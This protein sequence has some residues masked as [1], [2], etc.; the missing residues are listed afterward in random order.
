[1]YSVVQ[2]WL[3]AR[4]LDFSCAAAGLNCTAVGARGGIA[5]LAEIERLM[6]EGGRHEA[7]YTEEEL[8]L[9]ATAASCA[10]QRQT[11]VQGTPR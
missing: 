7:A 6:R 1:M 9:S 5:P 8:A 3:L 2:G 4:A 10:A 11:R